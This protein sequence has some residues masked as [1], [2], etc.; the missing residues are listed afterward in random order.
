[1][2]TAI[3]MVTS[4]NLAAFE[5]F[6]CRWEAWLCALCLVCCSSVFALS[7]DK[8]INEFLHTSW[9]AREGAPAAE[10]YGFAQTDDGYLWTG[11]TSG[12]YRFDGIHFERVDI[13]RDER[14]SSTSVFTLYSPKS[15]G[16]LW[17]GFL[18]GGVG[19]L[20]DGHLTVYTQQDGLPL[21]SVWAIAQDLD[22]TI[23]AGTSDGLAR[24]DGSH[25]HRVDHDLHYPANA[26]SIV[27]VFFD[28]DGTLWVACQSRL[29]FLPQGAQSFEEFAAHLTGLIRLS[30][31]PSGWVWAADEAGVR[32]IHKSRNHGSFRLSAGNAL[33]FDRDGSLWNAP[34]ESHVVGRIGNPDAVA[35]EP[36]AQVQVKDLF[37]AP[38]GLVAT[39]H[40]SMLEDREGNVWMQSN[41]GL[42]RFSERNVTPE[43]G[44]TPEARAKMELALPLLVAGDDGSIWSSQLSSALVYYKN[45]VATLHE[46]AKAYSAGA[47][48][49]DGSLWFGGAKGL[50]QWTSGHFDSVELP[51]GPGSYDVQALAGDRSGALWASIVRRGVFR[52]AHD[53]WRAYGGIESLP[54]M[55]AIT[56]STDGS[57]RTW[58]GYPESRV[59][60]LNGESVQI[61]SKQDGL[62]VGNVKAIYG[63]R[64]GVWVGGESGLAVFDGQ[65]FQSVLNDTPQEFDEI[66]GIVETTDGDLWLNCAAGIVHVTAAELQRRVV[67]PT[68]HVRTETFGALDGLIGNGTRL[69]PLP[70]A[71]E[72]TDGRLWF[73]TDSSIFSIDP[74]HLHRN[75][76]PPNVVVR[77]VNAG[78]KTYPF[79]QDLR[80]PKG[81]TAL[82]IDYVGL[83]LTQA[84]KVRYRYQLDGVDKDWQDV[85]TRR[86]AFY[87]NLE[88]GHYQ[89][90][91]TASNNDGV[92]NEGGARSAFEIP[93]TF[94][95]TRWFVALLV[96]AGGIIVALLFLLRVR[97]VSARMRERLAVQLA[98]RTRMARELHDTLLQTIHGS[99]LV[100]DDALDKA[101]DPVHMHQA[102]KRLSSFLGEAI[103]EG[104]AALNSLRTSTTQTNDLADSFR[105]AADECRIF[106]AMEV[107]FAVSGEVRELHPIVRDEI[108][109][110]GYE[111]I[112]NACT[113]SKGT[114][115]NVAISYSR[116]LAL[117]VS[118]DGQGIDPSAAE[119]R[120][121]EHFGLQGMRERAA[122]I[123]GDLTVVSAANAGTE[124]KLVVPG[125]VIFRNSRP[126][127]PS[128][129]ARIRRLFGHSDLPSDSD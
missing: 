31:S 100:A 56:L 36:L 32:R 48:A 21:G 92:W 59:A 22:G 52:R 127:Q 129:G 103:Q 114:R 119:Q 65:R 89:F 126:R 110:I 76:V 12:L 25:W 84:E 112:H 1:M 81:T 6:S 102:M 74:A 93:P 68:Y 55:P 63:R 50:W 83:S 106:G 122:R 2:H 41:N 45:G 49:D 111:A 15:G 37:A 101:A 73:A 35:E 128:F 42:D 29:F 96:A 97:Q 38:D 90:H 16:G 95:Q 113:H 57:G 115:L 117:R 30:E 71:I 79:P 120:K 107:D 24:L 39:N 14:L 18:F 123:S 28:S 33:A 118:D 11:T 116:D 78:D 105:R 85:G 13:P 104:R 23:W 44:Y 98:E 20:K 109:R 51:E 46:E 58:F 5:R 17:I 88:P 47:R 82:H 60:M 9:R 77:S 87:T 19:Y 3:A 72:G 27:E 125:D 86:Q 4:G 7:P 69:R 99:K 62:Q 34:L 80:L 10:L 91:V 108:Y 70:T 124:I 8:T 61:F 64:S 94:V 26:T 67:E 121:R 40:I 75:P 43:L 54:K 53:E 66:T